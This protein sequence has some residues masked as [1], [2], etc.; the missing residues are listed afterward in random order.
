MDGSETRGDVGVSDGRPQPVAAVNG[1]A[2]GGAGSG[3]PLVILN[4]HS[5]S[6]GGRGLR[7]AV[8]QAVREG[9]AALALTK[10]PGDAEALAREAALAGRD[11]IAAGGDG[12]VH[13]IA[14][15]ILSSGASVA[16]GIV[17]AGN[18]NDYACQTLGL[19]RDY[20]RALAISLDGAPAAMDAGVV[21]GR[22]FVN[23]LG[24]GIDANI[25]A[26]AE[27]LKRVPLLRGQALYY[28][29]SLSELIFHYDRCP[30]LT[31]AADG[32]PPTNRAYA[33]AAVSLGPTYGGGFQINPGADPRDGLFDLCTIA[34]PSQM[35]ALRLLPL[36]EKGQHIH[37]PEVTRRR[38]RTLEM[39]AKRPIFAHLDGEV[40]SAARFEVRILPGA[41]RVRLP[42]GGGGRGG[43]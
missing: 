17:P 10:A 4:P 5:A 42:D 15:G 22:Y 31:L 21:N 32:E 14:N 25:A 7:S 36:V 38:V 18:G 28:A 11:V 39:E 2:G 20:V 37:Q 16:L 24:V 41:L 9:R 35:R 8:E 34:K 6:G 43:E 40:L 1:G 29:A 23:S 19:P 27:R 33:L 13:E 3:P 26:A 30:Q 12:T